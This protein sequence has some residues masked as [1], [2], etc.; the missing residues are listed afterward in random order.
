MS[1]R[2]ASPGPTEHAPPTRGPSDAE[3]DP[4]PAPKAFSAASARFHHEPAD[5]DLVV[6]LGDRDQPGWLD[7]RDS[8]E[9]LV[10]RPGLLPLRFVIPWL[11]SISAAITAAPWMAPRLFPRDPLFLAMLPLL[12][13]AI[14]PTMIAICVGLNCH[15]AAKGDYFRADK[16]ARTL[17]IDPTR[18]VLAARDIAC[19]TEVTRWAWFSH[20]WTWVRQ[21]GVLA[22]ESG[23]GYTHHFLVRETRESYPS[24]RDARPA[25]R[26]AEVFGVPLHRVRLTL[27][28]SRALGKS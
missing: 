4:T 6:P 14:V 2:L 21:T 10:V 20:T 26:L 8:A 16:A 18:R 3:R 1:P 28:Q 13:T 9:A 15:F 23:G 12:W 22:R 17:T 27:A 11:L 7:V 25:D 24:R 19:I 5:A